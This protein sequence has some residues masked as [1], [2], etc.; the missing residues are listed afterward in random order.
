MAS[1]TYI[2]LK[3]VMDRLLRNNVMQGINYESVVDYTIDFLELIGVPSI[4]EE[5]YYDGEIKNYRCPLPCDFISD[6]QVMLAPRSGHTFLPARA[7]TDT[8]K[9][10]HCAGVEPVSDYTFSI[11][12]DFIFT[13]MENGLLKMAYRAIV[14]DEEGYPMMPGDKTFQLALEWYVK[15]QYFTLLWEDGKLEDKRLQHAEQEYAW[16]AGRCTTYMKMLSLSE[17]ESF[18]NSFRTLIPRDREF[19]KRFTL[20]G[21]KER[22]RV[23]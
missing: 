6:I 21:A 17:A 13:S 23:Q 19:Q 7:T 4:Y 2:S 1:K 22:L 14:T 15:V 12:R 11:N 8:I 16:A 3:V 20:D 18:F 10:Y 9:D 5:K